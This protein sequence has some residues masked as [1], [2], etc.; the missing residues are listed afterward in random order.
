MFSDAYGY[1][2]SRA[3]GSWMPD[4]DIHEGSKDYRI[5]VDL[6][7]VKKEDLSVYTEGSS[8]VCMSGVRHRPSEDKSG[9]DLI[10]AERGYGRFERCFEL[11]VPINTKTVKASFTAPVM[12]VTVEKQAAKSDSTK[13]S[14]VPIN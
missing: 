10:L 8:V 6:P 12:T 13:S 14:T 1:F 5:V 7:E 4:V 9:H 11:P 2:A 3:R